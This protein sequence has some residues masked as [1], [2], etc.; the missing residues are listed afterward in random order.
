MKNLITLS[1]LFSSLS[2]FAQ[3]REK[4]PWWPHPLWGGED[5]AGASNWITPEKIV[6]AAKLIKTGKTYELGNLYEREMFVPDN[7]T[8]QLFIPS[9]PTYG[10]EGE[11]RVVFNDEVLIAQI[12]QVGTQFDGLG[13][14]GRQMDI[15]DGTTTEVFYNGYNTSEMKNPFGLQK[16][17]IEHLKPIITTGILIDMAAS[18]GVD[19]LDNGYEVS[20]AEV[21]DALAKEGIAESDIKP[22][23]AILFNFGWWRNWKTDLAMSGARRP[24]I[25]MEVVQW[26]IKKQPS[27]VGSDTVLDGDVFNVHMEL[28]MKNGIFNLEWMNFETLA[29]DKAYQFM[30]I[31]TPLRIKGATGSPGRPLAI[32]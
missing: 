18:L 10:P 2:L 14:P 6:E 11:D 7:R 31:F 28:T 32:R 8:F 27:M 13:H 17:G 26:L 21:M 25:S 9:F 15:E 29:A 12:G 20:L 4:G 19:P 1:L 5:Q 24:R 3:T 16:L 23:D 30:F 22:G